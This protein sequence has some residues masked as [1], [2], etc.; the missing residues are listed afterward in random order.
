[1]VPF[2]ASAW[3]FFVACLPYCRR[4]NTAEIGLLSHSTILRPIQLPKWHYDTFLFSLDSKPKINL[5]LKV[6]ITC[7]LF[8]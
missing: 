8:Y 2:E 6:I 1:M 4:N 5:F 7:D 3:A